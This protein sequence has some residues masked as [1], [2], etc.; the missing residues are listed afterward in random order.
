MGQESNRRTIHQD[1]RYNKK[2]QR[3]GL[4]EKRSYKAMKINA[5]RVEVEPPPFVSYLPPRP[6][7]PIA[8]RN[9]CV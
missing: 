8:T 6:A 1:K 5:R 9:L 7:F 4:Q 2:S 3:K